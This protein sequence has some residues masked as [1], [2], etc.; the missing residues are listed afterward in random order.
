MDTDD[1]TIRP[2]INEQ[3]IEIV[4]PT[5]GEAHCD[6]STL[7]EWTILGWKPKIAAKPKTPKATDKPPA[8]DTD[9][10]QNPPVV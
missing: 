1:K 2:I 7:S 9:K 4:H 8:D 5:H 3:T 10:N 6:R